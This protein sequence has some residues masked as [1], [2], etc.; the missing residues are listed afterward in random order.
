MMGTDFMSIS[1]TWDL[2]VKTPM[3][4]FKPELVIGAAGEDLTGTLQMPG[5]DAT[6]LNEGRVDGER[7]T[8]KS[9]VKS[10]MPLTLTFEVTVTGDSMTGSCK[11]P[12]MPAS[13]VT[14]ERRSA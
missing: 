5:S 3:G 14:G 13:A 6:P 11:P 4:D 9:D 1:G 7:L 10:P 2:I 12:M 8:W